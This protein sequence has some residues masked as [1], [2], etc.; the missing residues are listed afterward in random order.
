MT[1]LRVSSFAFSIALHG[2]A[3]LCLVQFTS[4]ETALNRGAGFDLLRFDQGASLENMLVLNDA[5]DLSDTIETAAAKAPPAVDAP[6][7]PSLT[8]LPEPSVGM[9]EDD[10]ERPLPSPKAPERLSEREP[11]RR[12]AD[13]PAQ[14]ERA[15]VPERHF[16]PERH[17]ASQ[18]TSRGETDTVG[19]YLRLVRELLERAKVNPNTELTGQVLLQMSVDPSGK[20]L[21][22]K[23]LASSGSKT[24][25]D[26]ALA[27]L[28]RA[29]PLPPLPSGLSQ[30]PLEISVPFKFRVQ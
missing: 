7:P 11:I 21:S 4:G 9:A 30:T 25:D 13:S 27:S 24:L 19:A 14:L 29:S 18:P 6:R 16:V 23:V 22:R 15:A 20:V 1:A 26:A 17:L 5:A 12:V 8:A 3:I 2:L 10:S 28:D